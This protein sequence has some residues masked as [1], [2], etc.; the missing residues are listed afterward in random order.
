MTTRD[1]DGWSVRL[2]ARNS[3]SFLNVQTKDFSDIRACGRY[4][5]SLIHYFFTKGYNTSR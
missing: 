3:P 2:V 4:I 5:A 1:R